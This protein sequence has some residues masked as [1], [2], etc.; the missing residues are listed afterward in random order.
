[1]IIREKKGNGKQ[2]ICKQV[3]PSPTLSPK[4]KGGDVLQK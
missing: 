4:K 3:F 1:M 2:P